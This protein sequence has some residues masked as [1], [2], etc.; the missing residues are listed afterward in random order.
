MGRKKMT[1]EEKRKTTCIKLRKSTDAALQNAVAN[2][3]GR[4]STIINDA[5]DSYLNIK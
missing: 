5:L 2:G 1:D 4:K 3:K